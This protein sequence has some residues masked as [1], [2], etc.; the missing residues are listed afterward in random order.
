MI[1]TERTNWTKDSVYSCGY[2]HWNHKTI[3][4]ISHQRLN[5]L[6]AFCE[7]CIGF[8]RL[9][10]NYFILDIVCCCF[11]VSIK[12]YHNSLET[13]R[14]NWILNKPIEKTVKMNRNRCANRFSMGNCM[15]CFCQRFELSLWKFFGGFRLWDLHLNRIQNFEQQKKKTATKCT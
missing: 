6:F 4:R 10:T 11:F 3:T 14:N 8:I 7:Y 12:F 5:W 13:I 9:P 1:C 15:Y 2:I